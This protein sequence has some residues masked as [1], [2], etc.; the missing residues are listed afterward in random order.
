MHERLLVEAAVTLVTAGWVAVVGGSETEFALTEAGRAA[1]DTGHDPVSVAVRSARP[2]IVVMERVT[3]QISRLADA[4]SWTKRDLS[5]VMDS[6][7][8][9]H[10]R[11]LR[12]SLDEA[13]VQKLLP[14]ASGEW[15][16]RIGPISLVSRQSH[17]LPVEV[18]RDYRALHGLPPE[19]RDTLA[20]H[21][22]RYARTTTVDRSISNVEDDRQS[23]LPSRVLRRYDQVREN[24]YLRR[25]TTGLRIGRQD[26]IVGPQAHLETLERA[27]ERAHSSIAVV[28]PTADR[29]GFSDTGNAAEGV[30][31]RGVCVDL[32]FGVA[33]AQEPDPKI[34][35]RM[36]NELGYRFD[37][38]NG[39]ERL[40]TRDESTGSG[41][42]L[43]VYDDS[44]GSLVAVIGN[45]PW[46]S[47]SSSSAESLSIVITEQSL[48][49]D[50]ARAVSS[51]WRGRDARE[52]NWLSHGER[53]NTLAT[54]AEDVAAAAE[55]IGI[56]GNGDIK[57]QAELL[58]DDEILAA[59]EQ[60]QAIIRI[61]GFKTD[62]TGGEDSLRGLMLRVVGEG[63]AL[64]SALDVS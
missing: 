30:I 38:K 29:S 27:F 16:R 8:K 59:D 64:I 2:Q 34:F 49:A 15:V 53:W 37:P 58:V 36:A 26:I 11:I 60:D 13:Q 28:S 10:E 62:K 32:L 46:L 4:R 45:H 56:T 55:S 35:V 52:D 14:R 41:A 47:S 63:A 21:V 6:S 18:D 48:C 3:G 42:S 25:R 54:T 61:G 50:V 31:K 20:S 17:F 57:S 5:D 44:A 9:M 23:R 19:W 43:L 39:R 40:R 33:E 51:L 12:N 7:V 22:L 24:D 1:L